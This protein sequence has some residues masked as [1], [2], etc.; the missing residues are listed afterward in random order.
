MSVDLDII[1]Y[2]TISAVDEEKKEKE[3]SEKDHRVSKI[4]DKVLTTAKEEVEHVLEALHN[5]VH[6]H[7]TPSVENLEQWVEE[8]KSGLL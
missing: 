6:H 2:M 1:S 5:R 8:H 7:E 3:K 4:L